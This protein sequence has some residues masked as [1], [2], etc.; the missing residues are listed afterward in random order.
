MCCR[1]S[2][3]GHRLLHRTVLWVVMVVV[4]LLACYMDWE[5]AYPTVVNEL[6]HWERLAIVGLGGASSRALIQDTQFNG[7][8]GASRQCVI[9]TFC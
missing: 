5:E 9:S 8:C 6:Q 7:A 2:V 1:L 3:L 4:E